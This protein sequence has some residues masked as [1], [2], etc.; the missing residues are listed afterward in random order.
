MKTVERIL[1]KLIVIQFVFLLLSQ[2]I[3]HK[4]EVLPELH[5]LAR[6]EGVSED[7]FSEILE[8]FNGR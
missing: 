8:T 5:Q 3:F 6:Y 7:N 4:F 1:I 2:F